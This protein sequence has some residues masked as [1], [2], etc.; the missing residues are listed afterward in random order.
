MIQFFKKDQ[1]S[2]KFSLYINKYQKKYLGYNKDNL[3]HIG[4][5]LWKNWKFISNIGLYEIF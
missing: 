3:I 2:N 5:H 1:I 4:Q